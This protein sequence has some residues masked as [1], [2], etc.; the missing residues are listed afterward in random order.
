MK[1][2]KHNPNT[3]KRL[4]VKATSWETI[5]LVLTTLVAYPFTSNL[6]TSVELAL[7]CLGIKI[8]FYYQHEK[9]WHT[10]G[11]GLKDG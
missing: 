4:I 3:P 9:I 1:P 11:W 8:L 5:S 2:K 7:A 10:I 6:C